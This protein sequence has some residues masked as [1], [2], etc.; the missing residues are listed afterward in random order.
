MTFDV[1]SVRENKNVDSNAGITTS[2]HFVPNTTTLRVMNWDI[3]NL[4][5]YAYGMDRYQIVGAPK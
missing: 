4:V 5:S 2:G 1:A 3:E